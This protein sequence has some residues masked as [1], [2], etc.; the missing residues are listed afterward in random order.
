[1]TRRTKKKPTFLQLLPQ[2][3]CTVAIGK[4]GFE[5]SLTVMKE[6]SRLS[7]PYAQ[8]YIFPASSPAFEVLIFKFGMPPCVLRKDVVYAAEREGRTI[9]PSGSDNE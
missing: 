4:K 5:S 8:N 6:C 1:L 7:A 9:N 2:S 3:P